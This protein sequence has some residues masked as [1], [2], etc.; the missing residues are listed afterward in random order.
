MIFHTESG[1]TYEVDVI[2]K[3]IRR[4]NG[5]KDPTPR[6]GRDGE[7]RDYSYLWPSPLRVGEMAIIVWGKDVQLMPEV[8]AALEAGDIGIAIAITHTSP[9]LK[10]VDEKLLS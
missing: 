9:V 5:A 7:W 6:Q 1:S 4:L 8:Q 10:V 2:N 3:K